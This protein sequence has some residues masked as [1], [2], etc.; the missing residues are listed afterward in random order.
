MVDALASG[1]RTADEL[2]DGAWSE[3]DFEPSPLLRVA[4][5]ATLAAHLQKLR[6]EG[7]LPDGVEPGAVAG[8]S[9]A[10]S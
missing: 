8:P 9:F 3:V 2:L 10:E 6:D 7:R 4:A 1:A 5:G